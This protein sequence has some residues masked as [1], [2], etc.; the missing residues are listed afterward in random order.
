MPYCFRTF[1]WWTKCNTCYICVF[2]YLNGFPTFQRYLDFLSCSVKTWRC[3]F[4]WKWPQVICWTKRLC[5]Q[6]SKHT[7][8]NNY[9]LIFWVDQ[10]HSVRVWEWPWMNVTIG[11]VEVLM[12][13]DHQH[14]WLWTVN[15]CSCLMSSEPLSHKI[16]CFVKSSSA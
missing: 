10:F 5:W 15:V 11:L 9:W 8:R 3:E 16:S 1:Y 14:S 13:P 4:S 2:Q 6:Q 12:R 7:H